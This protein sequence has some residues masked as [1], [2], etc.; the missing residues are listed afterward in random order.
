MDVAGLCV[1]LGKSGSSRRPSSSLP[2]SDPPLGAGLSVDTLTLRK[3]PVLAER[4]PLN[5][6]LLLHAAW[7]LLPQ[8]FWL[9][10]CASQGSSACPSPLVPC[11]DSE[12]TAL[13]SWPR[14]VEQNLWGIGLRQSSSWSPSDSLK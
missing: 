7:P 5:P 1:V 13:S 10:L 12:P 2:G 3:E 8:R 11:C 6:F 14:K 9:L 4:L